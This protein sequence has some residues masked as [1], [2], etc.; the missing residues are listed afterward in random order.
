[1]FA[2]PLPSPPNCHPRIQSEGPGSK[3]PGLKAKVWP[4]HQGSFR[5]TKGH[6]G[7]RVPTF[8]ERIQRLQAANSTVL[9]CKFF[10]PL[11]PR[12]KF[13]KTPSC[14]GSFRA[15]SRFSRLQCRF[16]FPARL[17]SAPENIEINTRH[18][19]MAIQIQRNHNLSC[20]VLTLQIGRQSRA[21][22]S[23]I[24]GLTI[25]HVQTLPPRR[26]NRRDD[27]YE[28]RNL[29]IKTPISA[30]RHD[31]LH[32]RIRL[33]QR[34]RYRTQ[35]TGWR[36]RTRIRHVESSHVWFGAFHTAPR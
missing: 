24:G 13:L 15:N 25:L 32:H 35:P 22:I 27:R 8:P 7:P 17:P 23:F 16:Y 20:R 33:S 5:H 2:R 11:N 4:S 14:M 26:D 1:M 30:L 12:H 36:R 29:T 34:P 18:A 21:L 9:V 3:A 31:T 19:I 10:K 28:T 6:I